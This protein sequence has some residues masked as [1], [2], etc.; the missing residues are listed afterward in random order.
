MTV[1]SP[2]WLGV[3]I[4]IVAGTFSAICLRFRAPRSERQRILRDAAEFFGVFMSICL[5]G[6]VAPYPLAAIGSGFVD[7]TLERV[8]QV[9]RFD[10]LAWYRFVAGH[11]AIQWFDRAAYESIF[12]SP[13]VLLGYFAWAGRKAEARL[14]ILTFWIAASVTLVLFAF[15]PARGPLALLWR[16]P[17]PY[18]PASALYE[19][20]LIPALRSH[21]LH[22]IDLGNLQ[23]L[24]SA[25]SF[26]AASALLYI[27]TAWPVRA[28]RWPILIVNLAMLLATPV[29]GTHYLAD[30]IAGIVVALAAVA[31]TRAIIRNSPNKSGRPTTAGKVSRVVG[32]GGKVDV[33]A[34]CDSGLPRSAT[35]P[36]Q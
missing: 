22:R 24:V 20:D 36:V 32:R 34:A 27:W 15:V 1:V 21:A 7:T 33:G 13:A 30:I 35:R 12:L 28:L 14:F 9:L 11:P 2:P 19:A 17:L 5:I 25:P 18:V 10:W 23:G 8:D 31:G 4:G 26:H 29:E 16:G 3:L 6:A